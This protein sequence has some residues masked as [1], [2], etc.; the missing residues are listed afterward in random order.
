MFF[1]LVGLRII[2]KPM[3]ISVPK[4]TETLS[5]SDEPSSSSNNLVLVAA[6]ENYLNAFV[7]I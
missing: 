1:P 3:L 4:V 6:K 7:L 2:E 5:V